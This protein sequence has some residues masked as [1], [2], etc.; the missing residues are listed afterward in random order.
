[1]SH[2]IAGVAEFHEARV[3]FRERRYRAIPVAYAIGQ[4]NLIAHMSHAIRE[5]AEAWVVWS[6]LQP[7]LYQGFG[8]IRIRL[9]QGP[10]GC[11]SKRNR[12]PV[13]IEQRVLWVESHDALAHRQQRRLTPLSEQ[14]M[15]SEQMLELLSE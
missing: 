4:P 8:P 7:R 11:I 1:M 9:R 15:G 5:I 2:G 6:E 3:G 12:D 10:F 13:V 14:R